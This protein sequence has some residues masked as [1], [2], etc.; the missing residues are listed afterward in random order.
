MLYLY[1]PDLIATANKILQHYSAVHH[2]L[3]QK[4]K[5]MEL[6]FFLFFSA[7]RNFCRGNSQEWAGN[8]TQFSWEHTTTLQLSLFQPRHTRPSSAGVFWW[9]L[10]F[11]VLSTAFPA[12]N[13]K[14]GPLSTIPCLTAALRWC[15]TWWRLQRHPQSTGAS[16]HHSSHGHNNASSKGMH[17]CWWVSLVPSVQP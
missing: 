3:F 1:S 2:L 10:P 12:G 17:Q 8:L 13:E 15:K 11:S 5:A 6:R 7:K 14:L 4:N 16:R 9:H